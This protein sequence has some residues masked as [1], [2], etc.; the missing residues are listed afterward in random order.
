MGSSFTQPWSGYALGTQHGAA[1]ALCPVVAPVLGPSGSDSH[2]DP[3]VQTL[4]AQLLVFFPGASCPCWPLQLPQGW[5]KSAVAE[6]R[7]GE[8]LQEV[9]WAMHCFLKTSLRLA[10]L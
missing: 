10:A 7:V 3:G 8:R 6:L 4:Q 5:G 9:S 1:A 2:G